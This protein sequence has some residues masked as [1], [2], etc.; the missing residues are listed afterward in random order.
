MDNQSKKMCIILCNIPTKKD[1]DII[2]KNLIITKLAACITI[3]P[4]VTSFYYW[5]GNFAKE[6]E[7][8]LIIKSKTHLIDK[9]FATIKQYHPYKIP[10]LLILNDI[11]GEKNYLSWINN[12]CL[13]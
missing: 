2:A 5:Q 8:Q 7:M 3:I 1:V 13:K 4:H 9:I 6:T 11:T 12:Y 10:E